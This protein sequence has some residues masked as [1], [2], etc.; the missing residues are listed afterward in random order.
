MNPYRILFICTGNICRSPTA[1]AYM[2]YKIVEEGL[3]NHIETDSAGIH[4]Y[5][6]GDMPDSRSIDVLKSR[7]ID[8]SDLSARK[9]SASDYN[10]FDLIL[11]MDEGHY[12]DISNMCIKGC[13]AD[14]GLFLDYAPDSSIRSVPDPYYGGSKGFVQVLDL[15]YQ[16][17]EGLFASVKSKLQL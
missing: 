15:I 7:G 16:G 17:T 4:G 6:V 11:G 12:S 9:I 2:R 10:E 1:E 3:Q 8:M 5:H 14:I 13:R